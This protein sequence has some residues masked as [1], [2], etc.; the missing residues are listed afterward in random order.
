M[1]HPLPAE[2][3]SASSSTKDDPLFQI[4][5]R[6][7]QVNRLKFVMNEVMNEVEGDS[8]GL[9]LTFHASCFNNKSDKPI[10]ELPDMSLVNEVVKATRNENPKTPDSVPIV[11]GANSTQSSTPNGGKGCETPTEWVDASLYHLDQKEDDQM[12]IIRPHLVQSHKP[13]PDT[14]FFDRITTSSFEKERRCFIS[15]QELA[16]DKKHEWSILVLK[17]GLALQE[18]GV[19]GTSDIGNIAVHT[20]GIAASP[21]FGARAVYGCQLSNASAYYGSW[22]ANRSK[23]CFRELKPDLNHKRTGWLAGDTIKV[24]LNLKKWSIKYRLNGKSVC[25]MSVHRECL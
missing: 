2:V 20:K 21:K 24:V 17:S 9:E 22:N 13:S 8:N 6:V 23:R 11:Y 25:S 18:I 1:S 19:V 3:P 5:A 14:V 15:S 12:A 4:V 10:L 16:F 7:S